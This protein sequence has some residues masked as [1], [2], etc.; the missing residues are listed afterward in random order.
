MVNPR[1]VRKH[2]E[3]IYAKLGV[4]SRPGAVARANDLLRAS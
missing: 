1:T 4:A 2:L 3:H